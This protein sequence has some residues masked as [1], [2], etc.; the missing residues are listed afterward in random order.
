MP[1]YVDVELGGQLVL[2]DELTIEVMKKSGRR[3]RFKVDA[4]PS[5][6]VETRHPN[7]CAGDPRNTE[8]LAQECH[9]VVRSKQAT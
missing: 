7:A 2:G 1:V 5:V 3:V 9:R 8:P 4:P 6:N